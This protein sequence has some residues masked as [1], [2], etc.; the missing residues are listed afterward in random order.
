MRKKIT[1]AFCS[2]IIFSVLYVYLKYKQLIWNMKNI[3]T[4]DAVHS[5]LFKCTYDEQLYAVSYNFAKY[6]IYLYCSSS[7]LLL[8]YF[9]YLFFFAHICFTSSSSSIKSWLAF[10]FN[11]LIILC[12]YND[13]EWMHFHQF[14][15]VWYCNSFCSFL[16]ECIRVAWYVLCVCAH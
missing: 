11:V 8:F 16:F 1:C 15:V 6:F 12:E 2:H 13:V 7:S 9:I 4:L 14:Y 5:I 3:Y 10:S